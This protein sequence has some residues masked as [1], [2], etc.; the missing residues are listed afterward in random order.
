MKKKTNVK[1]L[2]RGIVREEVA[3]AIQ[4][5]VKELKQPI[6]KVS[7][8]KQKEKLVEKKKF[9]KNPL[10]N[11]IL[12]ET[13]NGDMEDWPTLG[14]ETFDSNAVD[15]VVMHSSN[16]GMKNNGELTNA[17]II[18]S[19]NAPDN[20]KKLFDKDYSSILKSSIEKSKNKRGI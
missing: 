1:T 16:G 15:E 2:I 13:A 19:P 7:K 10:L 18:A 17:D 5:V 9:S 20:I 3:L 6:Q 11:D 8:P 14:G 4:E 12:N